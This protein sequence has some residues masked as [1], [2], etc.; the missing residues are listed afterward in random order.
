MHSGSI[1]MI[2]GGLC[3]VVGSVLPWVSTPLGTLSGAGG[4][5]LWTLCSGF[6]AIAGALLPYRGVAFTHALLPGIFA[7]VIAVWQVGRLLQLSATMDSW[8][9]LLPG[10]G[11]VLVGGGAVILLRAALRI[12]TAA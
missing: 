4:A 5:G 12:R 6:I 11:L 3:L 2:I 9:K 1:P 7:A 10:I 8:G